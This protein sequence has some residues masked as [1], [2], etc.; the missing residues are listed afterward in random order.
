M[1][2]ETKVY[3]INCSASDIDFRILEHLGKYRE[4][5]E[6]AKRLDTV[7]SL[8]DFQDGCNNDE[9]NL[10]NSFILID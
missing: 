10:S 8:E 6:E 1:K 7:Y 9:I 5:K 3:I 4:I 2:K